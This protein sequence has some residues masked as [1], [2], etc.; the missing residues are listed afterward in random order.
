MEVINIKKN[1]FITN[2]GLIITI[3]IKQTPMNY[4]KLKI[5]FN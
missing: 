4:I 5:T 1:L 2:K 3:I